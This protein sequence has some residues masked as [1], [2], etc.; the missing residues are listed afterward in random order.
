MDVDA[1]SAKVT[2]PP[3]FIFLG[4]L[5]IGIAVD[6][7]LSWTLG[8]PVMTRAALAVPLVGGGIMLALAARGLFVRVG[9]EVKP[10]KTASAIVD[11]GVYAYSRNPMYIGMTLMYAG[12][13]VVFGSVGALL[14]LPSVIGIIRTQVIAREETYLEG[15]FDDAYRAY[16]ARVRRWV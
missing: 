2:F 8:L 5:L 14:L 11:S 10:W 12:L 3:P 16:K 1:D 9:T 4:F 6:Y 15:K 13:A 7:V